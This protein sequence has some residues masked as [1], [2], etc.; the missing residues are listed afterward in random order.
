MVRDAA[1][2]VAREVIDKTA[3]LR[4]R[5][6]AWP[7]QELATLAGLGFMGMLLP[8]EYG[9]SGMSFMSYCLALEEISYA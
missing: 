8:Q 4:D 5:T 2:R 6:R 3:A 9:G 7:H 1:R